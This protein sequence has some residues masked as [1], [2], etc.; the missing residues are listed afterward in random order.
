MLLLD[1]FASNEHLFEKNV[2]LN[3]YSSWHC[4]LPILIM[5]WI[6]VCYTVCLSFLLALCTLLTG[7]EP[8]TTTIFICQKQVTRKGKC[9]LKLL[10]YKKTPTN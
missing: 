1:E 2:L 6:T 3:S 5:L 10:L 4:F 8:T 7:V 9:P